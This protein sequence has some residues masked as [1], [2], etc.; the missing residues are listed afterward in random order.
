MFQ[1]ILLFWMAD[2]FA[3]L[4]VNSQSIFYGSSKFMNEV[5]LVFSFKGVLLIDSIEQCQKKTSFV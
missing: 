2:S 5:A 1:A 4:F 3:K